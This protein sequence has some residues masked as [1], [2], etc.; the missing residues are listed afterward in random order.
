QDLQHS[1][2]HC[3]RHKTPVIFRAT[4]QWFISMQ[5]NGLRNSVNA[6]ISKVNWIPDWGKKRIELMVENRP[7]WCISRQRC[8]GVPI[9]LFVHKQTGELHPETPDLFAKIADKIEQNGIEAWF[10]ADTSDFLG[11]KANDYDKTTDTLDVWLD[12]GVSHFAVLAQRQELSAVADLYLEGSDQHRGWFQSSLISAVAMNGKAPY[13]QVLTHGFTVDKDGKKMSK[14]LKNTMSPQKVVNNLGADILRL[15][16][17]STDYTGEMTVSDEFFKRSADSYR[18]IRN[19]MRFMLANMFDFEPEKHLLEADKMLVLDQWIVGKANIFQQQI[20]NKNGFYDKYEFHNVVKNIMIFCTND[21]GGFYL[22]IIKDRQYTCQ[23]NSIARRS[24][25][26]A[27]Y[28]IS[29]AMVRWIAPIL[30]FTAEEIWQFMPHQ[31]E[32]SI[33]L[34]GEFYAGLDEFSKYT[35]PNSGEN[36][37][38]FQAVNLF[39]QIKDINKSIRKRIEELRNEKIIGSSL[40]ANI[41]FYCQGDWQNLL[42]SLGSELRF[43]FVVSEA[44]LHNFKNKPADSIP[45]ND[46]LSFKISKSENQKCTRC[47][48]HRENIGNKTHPEL[49]PRCI[50]N[51]DGKGEKRE[52][53]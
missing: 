6:Q 19:T 25:Q 46:T 5:Q 50:E 27:L 14:S 31:P 47:W 20:A 37:A 3:W 9:T 4:P 35:K 36:I 13:K 17:S 43:V 51:V 7:D 38:N 33:F 1:Y 30:S 21:L 12:S 24:A 28:H 45:I 23:K 53:A 15:W 41:D 34:E 8:W 52:F 49:C 42:E 10:E 44:N 39:N 29:Q 16:I 26:T 11:D 2:P 32:K 22:D 48:H 40:E 18:R